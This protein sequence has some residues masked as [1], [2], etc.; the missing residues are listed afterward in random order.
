MSVRFKIDDLT[1][2]EKKKI[3]NDLIVYSE[4]TK[5]GPGKSTTCFSI[6]ESPDRILVPIYYA[7]NILMKKRGSEKIKHE[8][9]P[10]H[11][12]EFNATLRPNQEPIL[13]QVLTM[14][15]KTRVA[16]MELYCGFGKTLGAIYLSTRLR[17]KVVVLYPRKL[18]GKQWK[19]EFLKFAPNFKPQL[20]ETKTKI[21]PEASAYLVFQRTLTKLDVSQMGS[22]GVVIV[23][24]AHM[25]GT[26]LAIKNTLH[27]QPKY[28]IGLTATPDELGG[29]SNPVLDKIFGPERA[30]AKLNRRH[31]VFCVRTR[32]VPPV[33]MGKMSI[34]WGKTLEW[35]ALHK[36]RNKLIVHIIENLPESRNMLV[37]C[38]RTDQLEILKAMLE[39]KGLK[40][41]TLYGTKDDYSKESRILLGT[42]SKTGVGFS[43][44]RLNTLIYAADMVD[45]R[46]TL[47]RVFRTESG[48]PWI[49]D[50]V[51]EGLM[52]KHYL[53]RRKIYV[54]CG[55]ETIPYQSYFKDVDIDRFIG[56]SEETEDDLE[57]DLKPKQIDK[58][59]LRRIMR[60]G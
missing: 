6:T 30:T 9:L 48:V 28:L 59:V 25:A 50:V 52:Y 23:D 1:D 49:I 43:D 26:E 32:L 16:M 40:P 39:K 12:E 36:K 11:F 27:L 18:I 53:K 34:D 3:A 35:Q 15:T 44:S 55:G 24:E 46:Q 20:L 14:L 56:K 60:R 41:E 58:N 57:D 37:L 54:S 21:D 31:K 45:V 29:K 22:V 13:N 7:R 38:K 10:E 42:I 8:R 5:F 2:E 33:V 4:D 17:Y 19:S 51:D 47:G